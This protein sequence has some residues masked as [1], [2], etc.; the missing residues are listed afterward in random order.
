MQDRNNAKVT[1]TV[2]KS[3]TGA[4]EHVDAIK[5]TNISDS[6]DLFKKIRILRIWSRGRWRMSL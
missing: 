3:S 6:M 4:I 1:E 5:V 2:V